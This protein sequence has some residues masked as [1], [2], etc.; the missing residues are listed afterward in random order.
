MLADLLGHLTKR[1]G[2][3]MDGGHLHGLTEPAH[4]FEVLANLCCRRPVHFEEQRRMA[5][6]FWIC[7]ECRDAE[8]RSGQVRRTGLVEQPR[9]VQPGRVRAGGAPGQGRPVLPEQD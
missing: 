9:V 2:H 7:V 6:A 3:A 4:P 8:Q 5:G 1:G